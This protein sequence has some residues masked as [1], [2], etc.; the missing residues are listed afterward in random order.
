MKNIVVVILI[1][2][3]IGIFAYLGYV[4]F[5]PKNQSYRSPATVNLTAEV[6]SV[7]Q[8]KVNTEKVKPVSLDLNVFSPLVIKLDQTAFEELIKNFDLSTIVNNNIYVVGM[9]KGVTNMVTLYISGNITT[10]N[11]TDNSIFNFQ[12]KMYLVTYIAPSFG[13]V[14]I[15]DLSTG[16][17]YVVNSRGLISR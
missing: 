1:I 14:V 12:G 13:S 5:F 10:L 3:I 6:S 9:A 7:L 11:L 2:F 8:K 4:L 16:N 15:M 17:L